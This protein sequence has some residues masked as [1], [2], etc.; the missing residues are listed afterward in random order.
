[1]RRRMITAAF[2]APS[3]NPP[4]QI[5]RLRH[6][7][8]RKAEDSVEFLKQALGVAPTRLLSFVPIFVMG[9]V[10]GQAAPDVSAFGGGRDIGYVVN[11][12]A[13]TPS[14]ENLAAERD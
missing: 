12:S 6:Q 2:R 3:R 9:G 14:P 1:M 13:T 4:E 8:I 10:Y 11:I 7:A 5:D